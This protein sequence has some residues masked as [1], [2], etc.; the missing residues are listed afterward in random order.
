MSKE[1]RIVTP[2]FDR[3]KPLDY[4]WKPT[5]EAEFYECIEKASWEVLKGLGFGK[6]DT[7]NELI[8]ENM[9]RLPKQSIELPVYEMED[10]V[11]IITGASSPKP[12]DSIVFEI[13]KENTPIE[14]LEQDEDVLLFPHDYCYH[15]IESH[16]ICY[17]ITLLL[18]W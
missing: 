10:V 12:T 16:V 14:L 17:F 1:I 3:T 5:T 18:G 7:M 2:Q 4:E 9:E 15:K 6:W 8:K 11:S 13:G